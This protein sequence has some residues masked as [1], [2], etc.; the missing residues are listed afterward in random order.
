M[1]RTL[2]LVIT[3]AAVAVYLLALRYVAPSDKPYF[4][5]GIGIIGYVAWLLGAIPALV[6]ALV[7][8]PLTHLIYEQFSVSTS[9]MTFASSPAYLGMLVIAAVTLGYLRNERFALACKKRELDQ[10]NIRLHEVLS[11]VQE[12]GG[13]HNLCG[14]CKAIQNDG[15]NWQA[16]DRYLK[17]HTK[18]EFSHCMC[19]DCAKHFMEQAKSMPDQS[20]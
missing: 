9:Y 4:I 18:M 3:I 7:L 8:I 5:L 16:I 14:E 2:R 19:P 1:N 11:K 20:A 13:V 10:M 6:A 15:G 17:E 12:L